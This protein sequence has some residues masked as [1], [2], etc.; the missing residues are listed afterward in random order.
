MVVVLVRRFPQLSL[1][2]VDTIPEV[3]ADKK[4]ADFLKKRVEVKGQEAQKK[5]REQWKPIVRQLTTVQG[6]FRRYVGG[7]EQ[8][9]AHHRTKRVETD[10]KK[11]Q[12]R[13]ELRSIVHEADLARAADDFESAE[14]KCLAAIRIDPKNPEP[15]RALAEVY[16]AQGNTVEAKETYVFLHQI[17]PNDDVIAVRLAEL[18]ETEGDI[19]AAIGYYEQAVL[20]NDHLPQRFAKLA[21]LLQQL[22]QYPTALEAISQAV[23]IEPQNPKYLDMLVEISIM[24]GDKAL[25]DKSY[26]ELR[27]V[28]PE[29]Q[30]LAGFKERIQKIR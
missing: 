2:D 4:K 5:R 21:Q 25:A 27:M 6:A 19:R 11:G 9:L 18:S 10:E 15:Y 3:K 28:N 22:E 26:Q 7:V 13:E 17:D 1:L 24:V 20:L 14:K 8:R 29:N 30:K 16:M 12:K 23:D